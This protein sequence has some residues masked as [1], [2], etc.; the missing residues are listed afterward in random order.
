MTDT[1]AC[2]HCALPVLAQGYTVSI[3]DRVRTVCCPGCKAVAELIRDSGMARYYTLR[4]APEPGGVRPEDDAGEWQVFNRHDMLAAFASTSGG[5]TA[6]TIYVGGLYCTACSWLIE[7]TLRAVPGVI[8]VEVNPITHRL[9][10]LIDARRVGLGDLLATLARLG[11]RPQPLAPES[12]A[13]PERSEQRTALKRLLVASLGMMQAMM[14]AV[15]LYAGEF[16][17]ISADMERFLRLVSFFV[18]TPVVCYS[19]RPFFAGAV[20]GIRSRHPG[21]DVPVA[22]AIA[23]AYAASVWSTFYDGPAVWYD[24]VTMFV[25][26]LSVGRFLEMRARHR[27]IDQRIALSS[28]LPNTV[29]RIRHGNETRIPASQLVAGDRV[30]IRAGE[31]IPADGRLLEGRTSVDQALLN[32]ESRPLAK[33]AGDT[34]LAGSVNLD[35]PILLT[36]SRTGADTALGTISRLSDRAR[37]ARPRLVRVADR[38][39]SHLVAALLLVAVLVAAGWSLIAAERAFAITLSVLVVTCPCALALATPAAFAAAS[40]RL[41][42]QRLLVTRGDAVEA[43]SR[44]THVV[45]DKT[46]TLTRGLPRIVATRAF[47]EAADAETLTAIAAAIEAASTHPLARAFAAIDTSCQA[48][49]V[50]SLVGQGIAGTVA[51]KRYRLGRRAYAAPAASASGDEEPWPSG[52]SVY[53][54]DG[55][56]LLGVFVLDDEPRVDAAETLAALRSMGLKVSLISGDRQAAVARTAR[57]L[58]IDAFSAECTPQDKLEYLKELQAAGAIVVM[59]GDGINDAPVLA[60]ADAS[61]APAHA[62]LLAQTSADVI[63]LGERLRPVVTAIE[64]ARRTRRIV[65]QNLGWAIGYNVTALPLAVA[66]LVPPWLAAIGMSFSSL[67][68]VLNALRL[69]RAGRTDRAVAA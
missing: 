26:F 55:E 68:V 16:T 24:S 12:E 34:L 64:T 15:A 11:Y 54:G 1:A 6:A 53:I 61:I 33:A 65:A 40:T 14:F 66:G 4:D 10:S 49:D 67:I 27:S 20:R 63:M 23:A 29:I 35:A 9:R 42:Q 8:E 28:I 22:I 13:A 51:G 45:F 39:A 36:V 19:A 17:G 52:P 59:I 25:F 44:A 56:S 62:A 31:A 21:M 30:R 46:G 47:T 58:G 48:I 37:Y 69:S 2:F 38:I 7:T 18:T 60:G 3:D 32:G 5:K 57:E 41:A 50:E 43:M